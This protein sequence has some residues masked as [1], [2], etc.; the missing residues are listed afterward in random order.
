MDTERAIHERVSR[1]SGKDG[2][3]WRHVRV[4]N[5][6]AFIFAKIDVRELDKGFQDGDP[7]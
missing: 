5:I 7:W 2:D 1:G 4:G 6:R 3:G